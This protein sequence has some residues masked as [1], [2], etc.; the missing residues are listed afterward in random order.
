MDGLVFLTYTVFDE[1]PGDEAAF[2]LRREWGSVESALPLP[3][4]WR[5]QSTHPLW[6]NPHL[7]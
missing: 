6:R 4:P 5:Y 3:P 1:N 2:S 7:G